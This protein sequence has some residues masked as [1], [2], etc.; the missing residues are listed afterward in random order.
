MHAEWTK[1][2]TTPGNGWLLAGVVAAC[3]AVTALACAAIVCPAAGCQLD[4][5]KHSL[6]GILLGQAVVAVLAVLA[7]GGEYSTGM[8]RV[9][10]TAMP[11]RLHVMAAKAT[12]VSA[13]VIAAAAVAVPASLLTGRLLLG[14]DGW[15]AASVVWR[16]GAGSVLYLGLIGLLSVGIATTMRNS[17]AAIGAVLGLLFV[18]PLLISVVSEPRW[19]RR[20]DQSTPGAGLFIQATRDLDALPHSPWA[21]LGVLALWA[22]GALILGAVLL[23]GRDI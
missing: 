6:T 10:Y 16:A 19:Q 23:R 5:V 3:V 14:G 2:R 11:R 17:A 12:V 1:L 8:A 21:G 9:T 7:V 20:L 4:T 22:C 18:M 15:P 13:A